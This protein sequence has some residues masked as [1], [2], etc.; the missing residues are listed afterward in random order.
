MSNLRVAYVI[1]D[2]AFFVSH[3]LPLALSTIQKG[4]KVI[5]ITGQNI[6][7]ILEDEAIDTL[8]KNKIEYKCCMFSQG[9]INPIFEIVGL[10][11]L[12][13]FLWVF[14]P[15]TVHSVT[16][17]GNFMAA[18]A[19]NFIKKTKIIISIS[20]LGT[21]FTGHTTLKKSIFL[22][23]YKS[24]LKILYFRLNY[25]IIF[26]NQD[27]FK[28]LETILNLNSNNVVFVPGSGV[29]TTYMSPPKN[30]TEEM[31]ILLPARIL[32]EKG[33]YE[34]F[35]AAKIVKNKNLKA[36]FYIVGDNN[37]LNPSCIKKEEINSWVKQ[38]FIHY[39]DYQKDIKS[40]YDKT[41]IVCLPSWREGFPKVLMEAASC[42][43]PTVTTDVP[44]CRDAIIDKKTG[45]LVPL[46]NPKAIADKIEILIKNK[47]LQKRMGKAGRLLAIRKFDL[48]TIIPQIVNLYV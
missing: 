46:K 21:I 1:N 44:G 45:F 6:N 14:R 24:I 12:I 32:F 19:L 22:F 38:G 27:D 23:I 40:L 11:Q 10:F 34:F 42:G 35:E 48:K 30:K 20:G 31:N 2:A 8:R 39:L 36:N 7:K 26:Q 9:F 16:S 28:K 25:T 33:I 29:N 17:K 47:E 3:R 4:G 43:I 18:I 41:R 13:Y 37:S 15:T 5:V